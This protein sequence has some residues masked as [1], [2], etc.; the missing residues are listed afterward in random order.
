MTYKSEEKLKLL[1]NIPN[2]KIVSH[3]VLFA[4]IRLKRLSV[5][6][7]RLAD[8]EDTDNYYDILKKSFKMVD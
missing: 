3:S 7:I 8:I 4:K 2:V 1:S 5:R 6:T